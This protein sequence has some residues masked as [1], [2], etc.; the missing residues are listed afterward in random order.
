[1]FMSLFSLVSF[2]L[3]A[4][5]KRLTSSTSPDYSSSLHCCGLCSQILGR[6]LDSL[7]FTATFFRIVWSPRHHWERALPHGHLPSLTSL[8]S[9]IPSV[10]CFNPLQSGLEDTVAVV[11]SLSCV[12]LFETSWTVECQAPPSSTISQSL[13]KLCPLSWWCYLTISSSVAPFSSCPQSFPA[14]GSFPMSRLFAW[15]A[16]S[17]GA[18]ASASVLPMNIQ[19]WFLLGLSSLISLLSKGLK[20]LLQ[21]HNLKASV[22]WCSV[23]FM[24]QL[25]HLYVTTGKTIALIT[26]SFV[27]KVLSFLFNVV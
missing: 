11:W 10:L 18:S 26:W 1:M 20:S 5:L 25:S 27:G 15:G 13:L 16:Q 23:S 19:G 21:H 8:L 7:C 14:S 6:L 17:I 9:S 12:P 22:L 3:S 24:V 4:A 2:S